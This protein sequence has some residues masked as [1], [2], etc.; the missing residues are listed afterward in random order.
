MKDAKYFSLRKAWNGGLGYRPV[1]ITTEKGRRWYGRDLE[2]DEP[3]NGTFDQLVGRF[4]TEASVKSAMAGV[5][6]IADR[7]KPVLDMLEEKRKQA[8]LIWSTETREYVE[9]VARKAA[10]EDA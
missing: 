6:E 2:H 3:T 1:A 5:R 8:A 4:E 7:H 10:K 9:Y